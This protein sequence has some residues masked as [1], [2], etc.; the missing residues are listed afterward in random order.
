MMASIYKTQRVMAQEYSHRRGN[1]QS[2]FY[3]RSFWHY[4]ER[5]Q[6]LRDARWTYGTVSALY[7]LK[8]VRR[9]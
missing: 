3:L 1:L 2:A 4:A 8:H 5:Q 6:F 7:L 9:P